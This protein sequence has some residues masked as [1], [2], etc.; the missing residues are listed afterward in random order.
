MKHFYY[1]ALLYLFIVNF[2]AA[3]SRERINLNRQWQFRLGDCTRAEAIDYD[4]SWWNTVGLPHTFSLPYFMWSE[5]YSGYG[6]YRKHIAVDP[7]WGGKRFFLEFEGAF[8]DAEIYVNGVPVGSHK[9]GYTGFSVDVTSAIATGDNVVAVRLNNLW[10][11]QVAPRAGDHTFSGGLYRDVYLV[12]TDPLHITWYGT[13]VTTPTLAASSGASSTVNIQTEIRNDSPMAKNCTLTT[14]ILDSGRQVVATVSSTQSVPANSTVTFDQ[15]TSTITNPDLW[16]PDSP[17]LYTAISTVNDG[18]V[19]VDSFSTPFGFRWF[20]W[21]ANNG[22]YLNGSHLYLR[23]ANVHQDHAGWGDAV[24]NSAI[25]RDVQMV[26]EAGF[27]FIR[28]SHYPRD[29]EFSRACDELGVLFWSENCFWGLGG[30]TGEG[31]WNKAGAYP[32]NAGDQAAFETNVLNTLRDMIRIHRNHPSIIAWSVSNEPFFTAS[33]TMTQMRALLTSQVNLVHQLDPTRPAAIGGAQRPLDTNTRIDLLGDVA[34]YNGDGAT[35]SLFQNPGIPNMVTEYASA[36][37]Y[38]PG[39]YDDGSPPAQYSWR[40]GQAIWCMFDHGSVGGTGL[41]LLGIVDYFR[42][43]KRSWYWY[44]NAYAG[45]AP[46]A[47]PSSGTPAGLE[48]TA[49]TTH[50]TA[51]DGT[52][53]ALITVT[54]LDASGIPISNNVPVTLT[55]VSGPGEFPTGSSITF[56]PPSDDPQSDIVIRDGKAAIAFRTYYSGTSV[57]EATSPGLTSTAITITSEGS[58]A[59]EP[60]VTPLVAPRSYSRYSGSGSADTTLTLALNRPATAS[61]I[62]TGSAGYA[63]DGDVN[64]IWQAQ[65]SDSSAW[66][67]V[68]LEAVYTVNTIEIKF[69]VTGNY[70]YIIDVSQDGGSWTTVVNQSDSASTDQ[71]RRAVGNFGSNVRYVRVNFTGLPVGQPAA[72]AEVSVGGALNLTFKNHQLGGT[73]IGTSGSWNNSGNV[74]EKALDWDLDTFFDAPPSTGGNGCWVGLDFGTGASYIVRQINYCPRSGFASRMVGGLFQGANQAD[75]SDAVTLFTIASQP[76]ED[77]LTL[78]PIAN[79]STFRYVRYLSPNGG[80]GNVAE[81]EFYSIPMSNSTGGFVNVALG[82]TPSASDDNVEWNPNETMNKAF[83]GLTSTK[84][85]TGGNTGSSG[86]L[87]ADLGAGKEH[88]VARYDISSAND[89][90]NRDPKN[91]QMLGSNDGS[92]WMTLDT[93]NGEL[94]IARYQTKQYSIS[95]STAYRYYRLNI[96]SNYSGSAADGIQ[97][98]E[99]ALMSPA[100]VFTVDPINNDAAVELTDYTGQPLSVF[101]GYAGAD[102]LIFSKVVGPAWLMVSSDGVLSGT[103]ADSDV[104]ENSFTLRVESSSGF[105]DITQ[106]II[107]V[108]NRY[109]GIRGLEDLSG[110]VAQWLMRDCMDTPA[111]GGADLNGDA[112]VDLS[113]LAELGRNW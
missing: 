92:N 42:I 74:K 60:G 68:C 98:S 77:I 97:L 28:G 103:P 26:K 15:T 32:N 33:G 63:N 111:C 90:P 14:Q 27:N 9:G 61:S 113:D 25:F 71:T 101:T 56:R 80:W 87:Q 31:A 85:Y 24:V 84:W 47:W 45:I 3:S 1:S 96:L 2:A 104:G 8:Q 72:L 34:G 95:N 57:I 36:S 18:L 5:F 10:N 59:Y 82:C 55:V 73:I 29:P 64:T 94:F 76:T 75:F 38:R 88:V 106:M 50:L 12:A 102:P 49:S 48:L 40:S 6:W 53:D 37:G 43:P 39:S 46:P 13:F 7:S 19:D 69:P 78:Q 58:P 20:E 110:L 44:R 81:V 62:A 108:L 17:T 91:W 51:V 109:S 86:W 79:T 66:W 30:A 93:R 11:A 4:D 70:R 16:S 112:K 89:V 54:V 99:L 107:R 21:T 22:F 67:Q 100:P 23:G 41:A 83:D 52:Q 105:F 35:Q 65:T